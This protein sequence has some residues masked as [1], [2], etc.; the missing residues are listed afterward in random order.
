MPPIEVMGSV[1]LMLAV[2]MLGVV[3]GFVLKIW[4]DEA[5]GKK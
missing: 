1:V 5:R 2:F 3:L 4:N